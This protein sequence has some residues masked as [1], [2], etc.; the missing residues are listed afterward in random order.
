MQSIFSKFCQKLDRLEKYT[1]SFFYGYH[2]PVIFTMLILLLWIV[3]LQLVAFSLI[4]W[5]GTFIF[6][7]RKDFT[8]IIPLLLFV[9]MVFRDTSVFDNAIAYVLLIPAGIGLV[10]NLIRFPIKKLRV[11]NLFILMLIVAV[12]LIIGGIF[13]PYFQYITKG[14][15]IIVTT[16]FATAGIYIFFINRIAPSNDVDLK[17][18]FC[19]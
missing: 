4:I 1:H 10:F 15:A 9:P 3:N 7:T 19:F 11:D 6:I 14:L 17:K 2:Y 18:Y 8:P 16:G 5:T 13:S 12:V